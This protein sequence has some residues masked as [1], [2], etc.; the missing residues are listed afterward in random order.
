MLEVRFANSRLSANANLVRSSNDSDAALIKVDTPQRLNTVGIASD[1]TVR[2]GETVMALGYPSV[3]EK[4]VAISSTIENG[5]YRENTD[6]VP[7][8]FVSEGIVA[9]LSPRERTEN[10]VTVVGSSGEV[11]QMSINSTGAGNSGGP[12]FNKEGKVIGIFTYGISS[13]GANTSGAIPI[14]YGRD[15]LSAQYP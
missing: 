7:V 5:Q 4:M 13:G 1:D 12:V 8:P 15:L 2:V 3:A 11:I 14:K 10:G 9:L 6:V